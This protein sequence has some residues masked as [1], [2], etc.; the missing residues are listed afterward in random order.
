MTETLDAFLA[1]Y[2]LF[3]PELGHLLRTSEQAA[4]LSSGRVQLSAWQCSALGHAPHT[5]PSLRTFRAI[6][7]SFHFPEALRVA[8]LRDEQPD[9][10]FYYWNTDIYERVESLIINSS[11]LE[12]RFSNRKGRY[13][14]EVKVPHLDAPAREATQQWLQS[15]AHLENIARAAPLP[16]D[17]LRHLAL[18]PPWGE[19]TARITNK[20]GPVL[21][22]GIKFLCRALTL[23]PAYIF[24][25]RGLSGET[26][27][28]VAVESE[29]NRSQADFEQV[30]AQLPNTSQAFWAA[31]ALPSL[32]LPHEVPTAPGLGAH[33]PIAN[34]WPKAEDN[35]I[36]AETLGKVYK[37]IPRKLAK[38]TQP[39]APRRW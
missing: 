31:S 37:N 34:F 36:L 4:A 20:T 17:A 15:L 26:S 8:L 24:V 22:L 23:N 5:E 13:L 33:L 19:C 29:L 39:I 10:Y 35:A 18:V 14:L 28:R 9:R 11:T 16:P 2:E 25:L 6:V 21:E 1:R 7:E 12:L 3:E 27:L 38:L 32:P 30:A